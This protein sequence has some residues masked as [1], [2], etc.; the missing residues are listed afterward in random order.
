MKP[1]CTP[2]TILTIRDAQV[3]PP[4][5]RPRCGDRRRGA[6]RRWVRL[7]AP[8]RSSGEPMPRLTIAVVCTALA[9]GA[10]GKDNESETGRD[11]GGSGA[12]VTTSPTPEAGTSTQSEAEEANDIVSIGM[13]DIQL[14]PTRRRPRSARRSPG[15][16]TSRS[17]TT[18]PPRRAPTS[19]PTTSRRA[20]RSRTR[21]G[22]RARSPTSARSTPAR[23]ARSPSRSSAKAE[24]PHVGMAFWPSVPGLGQDAELGGGVV[25]VEEHRT[26]TAVSGPG[27]AGNTRTA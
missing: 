20:T 11:A 4:A 15:R 10:C 3:P 12:T 13:K 16:T 19:S 26:R 17:R 1:N 8:P 7:V 6:V 21:R 14:V 2:Y 9:L 23:S 5:L 18:S 25:E 24:A 27:R 22:R